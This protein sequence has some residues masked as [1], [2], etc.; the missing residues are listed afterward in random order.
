M[1]G[2]PSLTPLDFY[3]FEFSD[4]G[5]R[6]MIALDTFAKKSSA[7]NLDNLI[8]ELSN[9]HT[10]ARILKSVNEAALTVSPK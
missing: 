8:E 5:A 4:A 7:E 1:N 9:F 3:S 6:L 10:Q 2:Q